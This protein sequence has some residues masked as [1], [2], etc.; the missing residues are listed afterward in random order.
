[1]L[2]PIP[3]SD[4]RTLPVASNLHEHFHDKKKT[5]DKFYYANKKHCDSC[6]LLEFI[7]R[8]LSETTC[9]QSSNQTIADSRKTFPSQILLDHLQTVSF[10]ESILQTLDPWG[11]PPPWRRSGLRRQLCRRGGAWASSWVWKGII[12]TTFLIRLLETSGFRVRGRNSNAQRHHSPFLSPQVATVMLHRDGNPAYLDTVNRI[13]R[14]RVRH[15]DVSG[16]RSLLLLPEL[17]RWRSDIEA[18]LLDSQVL[19]RLAS[20]DTT[21]MDRFGP[22][23]SWARCRQSLGGPTPRERSI[24]LT[25]D[26]DLNGVHF[27]TMSTNDLGCWPMNFF[28]V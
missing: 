6:D 3:E 2:C 18:S 21:S 8:T 14:C 10:P 11:A 24:L 16:E 1:M 12:G 4:A 13:W 17:E 20:I 25:C 5:F 28:T 9:F 19:E 27:V 7:L 23:I 26:F 22:F 15:K